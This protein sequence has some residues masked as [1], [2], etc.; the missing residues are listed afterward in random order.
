[1]LHNRLRLGLSTLNADLFRISS[2]KV[3]SPS[4][5][6]GYPSENFNH[7]VLHCPLYIAPR[8]ILFASLASLD[9][10][11]NKSLLNSLI[12]GTGLTVETSDQV[13][14]IFQQYLKYQTFWTRSLAFRWRLVL[15]AD[16]GPG[17]RVWLCVR[18][19]VCL[20]IYCLGSV[21]RGNFGGRRVEWSI[22]TLA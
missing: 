12:F 20:Q 13:A 19:Y 18:V 11:I 21:W 1:M 5:S 14:D 4:C 2:S 6:C 17:A 15:W 22:F 8:N 10:P 3:S 9:I 16:L 7:Y